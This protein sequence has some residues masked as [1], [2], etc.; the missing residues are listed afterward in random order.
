VITRPFNSYSIM[1]SDSTKIEIDTV[2][3]IGPLQEK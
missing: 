2:N 1:N 3:F